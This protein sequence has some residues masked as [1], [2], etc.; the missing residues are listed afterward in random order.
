MERAWRALDAAANAAG[1]GKLDDMVWE[2]A[3]EDGRVAAIVP[4]AGHAA[5]VQAEGRRVSVYTLD[6]IARLL[7][8]FPALAEAK[9]I[10]PGAVVTAVRRTIGDPLDAIPDTEAPLDDGEVHDDEIPF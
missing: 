8:G 9:V 10:W 6:E 2:I 7:S 4:E 5:R 3:L 1:A